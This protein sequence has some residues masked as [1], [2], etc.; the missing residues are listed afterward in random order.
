MS[1]M[2]KMS[3]IFKN[4]ANFEWLSLESIIWL[5]GFNMA[6]W[7]IITLFNKWT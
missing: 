6:M 7:L 2:S 4:S 5:K 3:N 1:K